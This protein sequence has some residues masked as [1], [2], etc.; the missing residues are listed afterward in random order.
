MLEIRSVSK[1]FGGLEVLH[2]VSLSVPRGEIFGL[3]GPNG[4][5]KTTVYNLVTGLLAPDAGRIE[6]FGQ[7]LDGLPPYRVT[8][9]GIAR[10]FQNTRIFKEMTLVENVLVA[11]GAHPPRNTASVLS[12][13][14]ALRDA[15]Q[16]EREAA[17]ELLGRVGLA[18]KG[19]LNAAALSYGEQRR[20]ELAR[21][22][23]TAPRL[24]LLDEP[25]A[26]MNGAEKLRLME[27]IL[28]IHDGGVTV[29]IIEHD[30]RFIMGICR[31]IAVLSFG[32]LIATG[33][34]AEIRRNP[35]VIEAYLGRDQ[36]DGSG[37]TTG[38]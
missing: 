37:G 38:V 8:R 9:A 5:G 23:A 22:L 35:E 15:G 34:P 18:D 24:L 21:A 2:Q 36:E 11:L 25:A 29:M 14:R 3:I 17:G 12:P 32:R 26:G 16:R 20:L 30:M 28:K 4:A 19:D 33:P 6:F 1:R 7:R 27:D 13:W 31:K 10:T